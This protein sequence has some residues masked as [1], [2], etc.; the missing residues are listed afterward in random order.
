MPK[1][2]SEE[3]LNRLFI[4]T[5]RLAVVKF[6]RSYISYLA[7]HEPES[8][9]YSPPPAVTGLPSNAEYFIRRNQ[10]ITEFH[11]SVGD[12]HA[13][14]EAVEATIVKFLENKDDT[15]S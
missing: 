7:N 12:V 8:G 3:E 14:E 4:R 9:L 5:R 13:L 1:P 2:L 11:F 10:L 15:L 6:V